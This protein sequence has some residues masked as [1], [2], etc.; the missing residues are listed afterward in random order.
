MGKNREYNIQS[1]SYANFNFSFKKLTEEADIGTQILCLAYIVLLFVALGYVGEFSW[2]NVEGT[3][4]SNTGAERDFEIRHYS[5]YLE[6]AIGEADAI[7]IRYESS[8]CTPEVDE[9]YNCDYRQSLFGTVNTLLSISLFLSFF[10]ILLAYRAQ[11]YRIWIASVFS[12][13]L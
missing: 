7:D 12:I 8:R 13:A 6:Y 5:D 11:K 10:A 4:N 3:Q 2:F 9:F 1:S